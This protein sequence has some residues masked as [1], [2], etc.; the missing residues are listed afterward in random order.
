MSKQLQQADPKQIFEDPSVKQRFDDILKENSEAFLASAIDVIKKSAQLQKADPQS[1]LFAVVNAASINLPISDSLG[2]AY[3]VPYYDSKSKTYKA[4]FQIGYKGLIQLAMRTDKFKTLGAEAVFDSDTEE[5][6]Q[7]RIKSTFIKQKP[8]GEI[9]GY[10]AYFTLINGFEKTLYMSIDDLQDHGLKYSQSYKYDFKE[11]KSNSLWSS[12][13]DT[14]A[15]KTVLKLL[16]SKYAPMTVKMQKAVITDQAV[17]SSWDGSSFDYVDNKE[18][19]SLEENNKA[20]ELERL[21]KWIEEADT[22]QKLVEANSAIFNYEDEELIEKYE[23]RAK[24]LKEEK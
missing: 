22:Y 10:V 17:I 3:I 19:I 11:K 16:I 15:K 21:Q 8:E 9:I 5:T 13:F 2:F 4:Q 24:E 18:K 1:I 23:A 20:K 6:L 12:N 14:M 7:T